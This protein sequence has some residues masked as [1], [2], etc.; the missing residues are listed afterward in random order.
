MK[1]IHSDLLKFLQGEQQFR[2]PL[3]QRTYNW[4]TKH[5]QKLLDDIIKVANDESRPNHFFGSI[6]YVEPDT[7]EIRQTLINIL[8]IDGQQRL[9]TIT[10]LLFAISQVFL[11]KQSTVSGNP[12]ISELKKSYLI[13]P[14][15]LEDEDK[16][17]KL[18]LTKSDKETFFGNNIIACTPDSDEFSQNIRNNLKFFTK[19]IES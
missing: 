18:I 8:V 19:S 9:T 11:K 17:Y 6:V 12:S 16:K 15:S 13:N 14:G 2:I 10:L 3:Y 4:E 7:T 1:A 5:C